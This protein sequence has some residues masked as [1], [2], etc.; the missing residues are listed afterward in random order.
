FSSDFAHGT[1]T[2]RVSG[3]DG[4][5]ERSFDAYQAP[6]FDAV[7]ADGQYSWELL[8]VSPISQQQREALAAARAAGDTRAPAKVGVQSQAFTGTFRV[9]HGAIIVPGAEVEESA[10]RAESDPAAALGGSRVPTKAQVYTTDLIV[11]GSACVGV[12]CSS[13]ESFG[14]DTIRMDENNLRIHFNDTSASASFPSNDWRLTANDSSNGGAERFSVEDATNNKTPFT[15]EGN[16]PSH[17]LY[18]D[19]AGRVGVQTNSPAVLLHTKDGNSP[20]LRLEQDGSDGF[21]TQTWDIAGNET[22]FFLRDVTNSSVLPFRVQPGS[23]KNSIYIYS[24][25][26]VGMG[27]VDG[28]ADAS[29]HVR[30]T[31]GTAALLI[32]EAGSTTASRNLM[33]LANNGQLNFV[34]DRT[35]DSN[36]KWVF[37]HNGPDF[38]ISKGGTGFNEL[39]LADTG[40]LT[41][42][43][44]LITQNGSGST[45]PD[46]VFE[47]GYELRSIDELAAFI[48]ENGHLPNVT[49]RAEVDEQGYV[50]H[51]DLQLQTLE[52]VEELTLYTIQQQ[53]L[54]EEQAAMIEELRARLDATP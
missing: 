44:S 10:A 21:Q 8:L 31:D 50:N 39:S 32:E 43:G 41:I 30:R 13:T 1:A 37:A 48:T 49:S 38:N 35:A 14:F 5:V 20:T 16:S 54:I 7:G 26:D 47:A 42:R 45:Y 3:P 51:S 18:V 40:D 12:D 2:L 11:Q 4:V 25:G 34:L 46:Y 9:L 33:T 6:S 36:G 17:T 24:D 52:K 28:G 19:S 53:R 27:T 15:I 23:P 22:N 29:L